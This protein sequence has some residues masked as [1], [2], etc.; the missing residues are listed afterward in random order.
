MIHR[1]TAGDERRLQEL[2]RRF[3]ERVPSNEEAASLLGR[4]DIYVWVADV[5]GD[6]AGF[7]YAYVLSRIDGDISVFL[8]ELEV[9]ARFR[10]QGLGLALVDHAR[11]LAENV[12][13]LKMWVDTSYENEAAKRT[14]AAAGGQPAHEPTLVYGWRFR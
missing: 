2:C 8:Y 6:L 4:N 12:G 5:E 10:C 1:L 7:A 3:K 14:Y 11:A 13:A 9:D